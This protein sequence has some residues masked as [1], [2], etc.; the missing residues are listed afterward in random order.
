MLGQRHARS[1]GLGVVDE[2]VD[3]AEL[4]DS[5]VDDTLHH[6][7]I[8]SAGVDIGGHDEHANAVL[9]LKL[10][11]GGVE[12]G[13]VAAGDDEVRALLG[14][15]GGDTVADGTAA[16]AISENGSACTGDNGGLTSKK[17]HGSTPYR[18]PWHAA[19]GMV[20]NVVASVASPP[21]R[22][23]LT[24]TAHCASHVRHAPSNVGQR[25]SEGGKVPIAQN[26]QTQWRMCAGKRQTKR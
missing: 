9:L 23:G 24:P 17:T 13:L 5:L 3:T 2:H 6:G 7:L 12:L 11:L 20:A 15:G 19:W 22:A 25:A 14:I 21:T 18:V 1:G 16:H 8:V 26:Q 10:S 4:S